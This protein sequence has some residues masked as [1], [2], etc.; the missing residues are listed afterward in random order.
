MAKIRVE[1]MDNAPAWLPWA[2][3]LILFAA[4]LIGWGLF[5]S[6]SAQQV[7]LYE[8]SRQ[9]G[10][11]VP[12]EG[13][14][15]VPVDVSQAV[16]FSDREMEQVATVNGVTLYAHPTRGMGGGGGETVVPDGLATQPYGRIYL[17]MADGRYLPMVWSSAVPR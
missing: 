13:R 14:R 9:A 1:K 15:W 3:L 7:G 6:P 12:Y 16:R 17:R 5:S 4:L 8:P 10:L 11:V 2:A